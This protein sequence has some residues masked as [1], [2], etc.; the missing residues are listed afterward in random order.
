MWIIFRINDYPSIN[1]L[2]AKQKLCPWSTPF[3]I[4]KNKKWQ[5]SI[6]QLHSFQ[7]FGR[8]EIIY[9]GV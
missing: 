7:Y 6:R 1:L 9:Q 5:Y 2:K 4:P 3:I 8:D